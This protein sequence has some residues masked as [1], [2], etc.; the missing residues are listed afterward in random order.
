MLSSNYNIKT[1]EYILID[2]IKK[3]QYENVYLFINIIKLLQYE[4]VK[5]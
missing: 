3:L 5:I 4:N 1:F 2:V